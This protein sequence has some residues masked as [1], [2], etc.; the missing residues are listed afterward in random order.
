MKAT[1]V[2]KTY[3]H[4]LFCLL[5]LFGCASHDDQLN[6]QTLQ[7]IAIQLGSQQSWESVRKIIKCYVF[8]K[9]KLKPDVDNELSHIDSFTVRQFGLANEY[10]YVPN[11]RAL[12]AEL[13]ILRIQV[14][15]SGEIEQVWTVDPMQ[16]GESKVIV[17]C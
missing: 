14:N 6:Q 8:A 16:D 3:C 17:T 7:T 9:G 13:G 1:R 4:L 15:S 10:T 2:I 12:L 5:L 11:N